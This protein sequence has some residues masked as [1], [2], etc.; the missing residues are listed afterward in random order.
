VEGD[1]VFFRLLERNAAGLGDVEL[2]PAFVEG[3][4]VGRV[5]RGRGTARIAAGESQ[6]RSKSLATIL[7]EHPRFAEPALVKLD[8]DGMDV[9]ILLANVELL[10]RLRPTLFF[11]YDPHLGA[12]PDVFAAL[13]R[14]GYDRALVYENTGEYR[15]RVELT[16]EARIGALHREY[17]GQGGAR[18]IDVCVLREGAETPVNALL[19][20]EGGARPLG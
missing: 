20:P 14:N 8:T 7:A 4:A 17:T 11:E 18:Y 3:P 10:E 9:P 12:S 1:D 13:S 15:G 19:G 6:L 5:E 16:D 2:E